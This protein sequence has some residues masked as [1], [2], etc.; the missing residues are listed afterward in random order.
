MTEKLDIYD[1]RILYQLDLDGRQT[2][3]QIGNKVRLSKQVVAYRIER[4]EKEGIIKGYSTMIDTSLL[5]YTTFRVYLKLRN[6][7]EVKTNQF[8]TYLKQQ[9]EIWAVVT[10][11][12]SWDIALG[13]AVKNIYE[14]YSIWESLLKKFLPTI[15]EYSIQIYSPIYHFSK[16][17]L[18]NQK[19]HSKIR[20]LGGNET[21]TYDKTD[22]HILDLLSIHARISAVDISQKV[23]LTAEAVA[24]RIRR[25]EQK[26]LIQGYRARIDVEK[27]GYRFYKAEIRLQEYKNIST[28]MEFCHQHPHIYQVD[29]TIGG[30]TLE[31]EFHVKKVNDMIS[32]IREM[33]TLIENAIE[34]Y[35]YLEVLSEE[36]M[37]YLPELK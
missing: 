14:F 6:S 32:I 37:K 15:K 2:F 34:S 30:E 5:G 10:L 29:K 3:A 35:T 21:A 19:D 8:L 16:A 27:I 1:Y 4:L 22:L 7:T 18:I 36:K 25:L 17:Y 12:G 28:L 11:A 26:G 31:I 24:A 33:N 9:K 20:V 23:N 13:V